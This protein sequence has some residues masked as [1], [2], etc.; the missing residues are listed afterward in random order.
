MLVEHDAGLLGDPAVAPTDSKLVSAAGQD[1]GR[2]DCGR[3][4]QRVVVR[5]GVKHRPEADLLGSL[6]R[7][8]EERRG[9][10]GDREFRI[11][12]V[13]DRGV[14]IV[15]E[16]VPVHDL[17]EDFAVQLLG[18]LSRVKLYLR[19]QAEPHRAPHLPRDMSDPSEYPIARH[20]GQPTAV[21]GLST[22]RLANE[23]RAR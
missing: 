12:E 1:V 10:R 17:L 19:V 15:A 3:Q 23:G 2:R 5:E 8:G 13:L 4:Y 14:H 20:T 7:G 6:R 16:P 18:A 22:P 9:I 11:E 21:A